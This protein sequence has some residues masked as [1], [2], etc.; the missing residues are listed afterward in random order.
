MRCMYDMVIVGSNL[1]GLSAAKAF[2]EREEGARVLILA[3]STEEAYSENN[4]IDTEIYAG[5]NTV[6]QNLVKQGHEELYRFC[7]Q[8]SIPYKKC[9]KLIV[10]KDEKEVELLHFLQRN[11]ENSTVLS[12]EELFEREP[13]ALGVGALYLPSA[14]IVEYKKVAS[15]LLQEV[16]E[17]G[18]E[19]RYDEK[20][21]SIVE[22]KKSVVVETNNG[23]YYAKKYINCEESQS[24]K[25]AKLS[26]YYTDIEKFPLQRQYY[27][28]KEAKLQHIVSPVPSALV[29]F[30]NIYVAP[31]L[32]GGMEVGSSINEGHGKGN[33]KEFISN[34]SSIRK[35][36]SY[37]GMLGTYKK[38]MKDVGSEEYFLEQVQTVIPSIAREELIPHF[39]EQDQAV[40]ITDDQFRDGF[41]F[42]NGECSAHVVQIPYYGRKASFAIGQYLVNQVYEPTLLS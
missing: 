32:N 15:A 30:V 8:H 4:M 10:A 22:G 5:K 19:I 34:I 33:I 1:T 20:V 29:P 3:Q 31:T 36:A 40:V 11:D 24:D 41:F 13:F 9:G 26:D 2:H 14:G 42:I 25:V 35:A 7:D 28:V 39:T 6:E 17:S 16:T 12:Q 27:S 37:K 23:A 38:A 18:A 21:K